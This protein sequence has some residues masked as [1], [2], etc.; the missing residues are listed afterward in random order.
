[1]RTSIDKIDENFAK[2]TFTGEDDIV[3]YNVEEE[4]LKLYGV[5]REGEHF[6]RVPTR[7][8]KATSERI[9]ELNKNTSGG[10]VR[11][12]TNSPFIA[13]IC[14]NERVFPMMHMTM[15]G[16]AGIDIY[17]DGNANNTNTDGK[18]DGK[19]DGS[20][21]YDSVMLS[22]EE[23]EAGRFTTIKRFASHQGESV[24]YTLHLPLYGY[25][26][27][28]FVGIKKGCQITVGK[29]YL[30]K[31]PI[32][33]YGSSITQGGCASRP[34]LSYTNIIT[35]RL[36]IDTL[37]LGFSGNAKG[38][39]SI[40]EHIASLSMSAF[41]CDYDYNAPTVEH[42][43]LTHF[44]LYQ[45]IREKHPHIPYIMISRPFSYGNKTDTDSR[46]QVILDSYHR[47]QAMGDTSVY[48]IDGSRLFDPLTTANRLDCTNTVNGATCSDFG[49]MEQEECTVDRIHPNDLGFMRMANHIGKV[50]E[51]RLL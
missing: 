39:A 6:V 41:V 33:F 42:L 43:A 10:R 37:N 30:D 31:K 3:W 47:A 20:V 44:P 12:A 27:K 51:D 24:N 46:R 45:T 25:V 26:K 32:V 13:L 8:A 18:S 23:Q 34:G 17:T 5:F 49:S 16:T 36:N 22:P 15:V 1:M 2:V 38:E 11:F 28:L 19:A 7:V 35:R 4:P 50:I 29:P 21:F 40:S 48:F 9:E 14:E